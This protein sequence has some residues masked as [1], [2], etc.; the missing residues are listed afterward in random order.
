MLIN[1]KASDLSEYLRE[2]G[3]YLA[4]S[5]LPISNNLYY[6]AYLA[7]ITSSNWRGPDLKVCEASPRAR[8]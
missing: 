5:V 8:H 4:H 6:M 2:E 3:W 7:Q 1:I